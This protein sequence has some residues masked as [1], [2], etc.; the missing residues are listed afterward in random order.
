MCFHWISLVVSLF[1]ACQ[2]RLAL[3]DVGNFQCM[4]LWRV[5][6]QLHCTFTNQ[7]DTRSLHW[8]GNCMQPQ[9]PAS[10]LLYG[11]VF[12]LGQFAKRAMKLMN[13]LVHRGK[14]PGDLVLFEHLT[15]MENEASWRQQSTRHQWAEY[16]RSQLF[17]DRV[18]ITTKLASW[19]TQFFP[20]L[21]A[22]L[23]P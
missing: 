11:Q 20:N 13:I 18:G 4:V 14:S 2:S 3:S 19:S 8:K 10:Q 23:S 17:K 5:Y 9:A 1:S 21:V 12:T 22:K 16:L 7:S 15:R 6:M